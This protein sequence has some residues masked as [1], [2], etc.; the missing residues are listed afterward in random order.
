MWV[1]LILVCVSVGGR[2]GV[3]GEGEGRCEL[4]F[5][6]RVVFVSSSLTER[7]IVDRHWTLVKGGDYEIKWVWI[8]CGK[9]HETCKEMLHVHRIFF[10]LSQA[11]IK[12]TVCQPSEKLRQVGRRPRSSRG[13]FSGGSL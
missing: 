4:L 1:L 6:P 3:V 2:I 9:K 7:M 5:F 12:G 10:L 8:Y 13:G 11:K